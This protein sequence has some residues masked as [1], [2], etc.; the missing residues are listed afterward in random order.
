MQLGILHTLNAMWTHLETVNY[1]KFTCV[2]ILLD[3]TSLI[4]LCS[5]MAK[6]VDLTLSSHLFN[7]DFLRQ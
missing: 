5:L 2:W 1:T 6:H 3:Q 4:A 7:L